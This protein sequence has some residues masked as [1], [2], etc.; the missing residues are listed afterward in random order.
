MCIAMN[1][2]LKVSPTSQAI[3]SSFLLSFGRWRHVAAAPPWPLRSC[4][5][6][7]YI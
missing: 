6:C 3:A 4:P 5:L 1:S 7:H 2:S